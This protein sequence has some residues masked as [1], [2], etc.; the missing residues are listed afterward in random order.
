[1][2]ASQQLENMIEAHIPMTEFDGRTRE[3][4]ATAVRVG[5][6]GI[7]FVA[8]QIPTGRFAWLEFML[9]DT[10]YRVRALA[11][12]MAVIAGDGP[13]HVIARYKHV[14]PRDRVALQRFL[15]PPQAA[16]A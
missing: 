13:S 7:E 11:E 16:V 3:H 8:E 5:P 1:M 4:A 12:V 10:G 15:N 6:N 2:N 14:F 9:P